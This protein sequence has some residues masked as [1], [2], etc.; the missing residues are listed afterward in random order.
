VDSAHHAS[1]V[2]TPAALMTDFGDFEGL[3]NNHPP[4]NAEKEDAPIHILYL[5]DDE[6]ITFLMKRLLEKKR[7]RVSVF[8][9]AR[10]ALNAFAETPEQ[11]DLVISDYNMPGMSGVD[12]ARA[13]KAL[14]INTP[15]AITS[16]DLNDSLRAEAP[17][18]GVTELIYKPNSV[19]ELF[20]AVDRLAQSIT[21]RRPPL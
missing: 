6:L 18:A 7:Y 20:A 16:G 9:D 13:V 3:E 17:A 11:F 2:S 14:S 1:Q 4:E 21:N 8:V 19:E 12:F 15:V 5:D 10:E